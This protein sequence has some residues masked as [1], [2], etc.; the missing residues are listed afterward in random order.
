MY[1]K[2]LF[3]CV[4]S[5]IH[6]Y[7]VVL[8]RH[9]ANSFAGIE[10]ANK[11]EG[12]RVC[13]KKLIFM[14][15]PVILFTWDGWWTDMECTFKGPSSLFQRWNL[16]IRSN[17]GLLSAPMID[18][19]ADKWNILIILRRLKKHGTGREASNSELY[20]SRLFINEQ[21]II[22]A[23]ETIPNAVVTAMDLAT[24]SFEKQIELMASTSI[25]VGA[26][27]AGITSSMHMP[28]G[29]KRCCGVLEF[30]PPGEFIPI[31]G[32]GNMIRRMGH[33][34]ERTDT[35]ASRDGMRIDTELMIATVRSM[36]SRIEER[37]SCFHPDVLEDPYFNNHKL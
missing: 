29:T 24:I 13:I 33:Y 6:V 27:G 7:H 35:R 17:Y 18:R 23:M 9:Y 36:M 1:E 34:Y 31:R 11:F 22:A 32:H 4:G 30:Y 8:C 12:K 26:H 15:R 3:V 25:V 20:T 5:Q 10:L 16:H 14:P 19:M 21:E 28:V 37:P 2:E